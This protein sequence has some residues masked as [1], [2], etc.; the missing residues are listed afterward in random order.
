MSLVLLLNL[1]GNGL[2][3]H[4]G[5]VTDAIGGGNDVIFPLEGVI[6][7]KGGGGASGGGKPVVVLAVSVGWFSGGRKGEWFGGF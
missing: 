4:L 3:D 5:S 1:A 7:D 6:R 2:F